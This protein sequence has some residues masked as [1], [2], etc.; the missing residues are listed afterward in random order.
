[1]LYKI[2]TVFSSSIKVNPCLPALEVSFAVKL[3]H[4]HIITSKIRKLVANA[5]MLHKMY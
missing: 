3:D 5:P 1:M 2:S 4:L